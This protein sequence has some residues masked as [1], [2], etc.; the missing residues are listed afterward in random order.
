M[1]LTSPWWKYF[2][3]PWIDG[4]VGY[5]TNVLALQMTFWPIE[6]IGIPLFR[7]PNEPWGII[8]WQGIIPTKAEKMASIAFDLITTKLIN[9]QQIFDQVDP[10]RFAEVMDDALLLLMD[11]VIN[12]VAMETMPRAW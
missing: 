4:I 7:I 10:N 9:I 6:F 11:K 3:I 12:E 1:A 8:G 2:L 5:L